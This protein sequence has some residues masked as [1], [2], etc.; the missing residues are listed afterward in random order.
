MAN[1]TGPAVL[2]AATRLGLAPRRWEG[3]SGRLPAT[4]LP[5]LW[6]APGGRLS[7]VV[8]RT[9]RFLLVARED[10]AEPERVH[11]VA[12]P[13][14]LHVFAGRDEALEGADRPLL[15]RLLSEHAGPIAGLAALSVLS[16]LASIALGLVVMIAFDMVIPGGQAAPL[17]ALGAGFLGALACDVALRTM[18]ARG[19]G[20]IG[21]RAERQVLGLVFGKVLR[22][23]LSAVTS[24]DPA[25]QVM[26]MRDLE[27]SREVFTGPLPQ[28]ILQVPLVIVFLGVIWALAGLVVVVP[29]LILPVQVVFALFLV[30]RAREKERRAGLLA[31]ERRRL[32]LETLSH[33]GTLRAT[34]AEAAWLARFRDISAAAAAAHARAARASHAVELVAQLGLPAAA[35]GVAALGASLVIEGRITAGALVAAIMLSWRVIVPLQSFF[36][37]VSRARQVADS[38]AQLHRLQALAEEPRPAPDAPRAKGQG[39]TLRLDGVVLRAPGGAPLL[40]GASLA[41]PQG[42]RVALTGPSGA[43]KSTLLRC[44]LGLVPPQGGIVTLGGVNIAQLDPSALRARIGYLPQRPALIYGTVAQNLRLAAPGAEDAELAD[45]CEEVGILEDILALPEGFGTRLNDLDKARLPQSLLQGLALAQA[46][47]RRPEILLLDD[48]TRAL[49][50][51]R[52]ERL[53]ALLRRLHGQVGVLIVTH[54]PDLI[55]SCDRAFTLGQGVLRP[56]AP[57]AAAPRPETTP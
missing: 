1:D 17:L 47:L 33:A 34:G 56:L 20:R 8:G 45:A 28:L 40:A 9:D 55:R 16:S 44:A 51:A 7:I 41:L 27:A 53:A 10:R 12:L 50:R 42:A 46:L 54:R 37:A 29:L 36:L 38:V 19:I 14:E 52:E 25:A 21:E 5:A 13:G 43:G 4:L 6:I 30:P 31:A 24:Q 57:P 3:A 18:L 35:C 23:P 48:P 26:R 32:I 2:A 49:D 39:R 22:L 15:P 11:A